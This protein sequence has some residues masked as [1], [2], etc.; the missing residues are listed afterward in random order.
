[1]D[2]DEALDLFFDGPDSIGDEFAE[3]APAPLQRDEPF[4]DD[5]FVAGNWLRDSSEEPELQPAHIEE[6]ACQGWCCSSDD[7]E[8]VLGDAED[9]FT[10]LEFVE[11]RGRKRKSQGHE[12]EGVFALLDAAVSHSQSG[13]EL[14]PQLAGTE[15][16]AWQHFSSAEIEELTPEQRL[17]AVLFDIFPT[18]TSNCATYSLS[19]AHLSSLTKMVTSRIPCYTMVPDADAHVFL[20]VL[21]F[22]YCYDN[23]LCISGG[24][25]GYEHRRTGCI[26]IAKTFDIEFLFLFV[27]NLRQ[28]ALALT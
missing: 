5:S 9:V 16:K 21:F 4:L 28:H 12:A 26:K 15:S 6:Q 19:L 8:S 20:F 7:A 2:E 27:R 25:P 11:T 10:Q 18:K 22:G 14:S 23:V 1:M 24:Q 3:V 13:L 17:G